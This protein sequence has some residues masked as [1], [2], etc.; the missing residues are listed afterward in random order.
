MRLIL[1][2]AVALSA[3]CTNAPQSPPDPNE[4][5]MQLFGDTVEIPTDTEWPVMV[6]SGHVVV[7]VYPPIAS[8]VKLEVENTDGQ[9]S[10]MD[11]ESPLANETMVV[12]PYRV[13]N[14]SN[15]T[16]FAID[17]S[18]TII[19]KL[20]DWRER[21]RYIGSI[22]HHKPDRDTA[23]PMRVVAPADGYLGGIVQN[24]PYKLPPGAS[25]AGAAVFR[26]VDI[27]TLTDGDDRN[28][29]ISCVVASDST[30][31]KAAVLVDIPASFAV[32][33]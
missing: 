9:W 32:P 17:D 28:L 31:N 12:V 19:C 3:G 18:V 24:R 26:A 14:V 25:A 16:S 27:A 33:K 22:D 23:S 4:N 8:K 30:G 15:A 1:L 10:P 2:I 7:S 5:T 11:R 6:R 21:Q 13:A 20:V 29:A